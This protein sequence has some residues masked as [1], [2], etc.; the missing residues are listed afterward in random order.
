MEKDNDKRI[1]EVDALELASYNQHDQRD[2][3]NEKV[4]NMEDGDFVRDAPTNHM[5]LQDRFPNY[6]ITGN[7]MKTGKDAQTLTDIAKGLR[8]S[9]KNVQEYRL[10]MHEEIKGIL[11]KQVFGG[12]I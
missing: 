10:F 11:K 3:I 12:D 1:Y 5:K 9:L 7:S 8:E 2:A 4:K 6:S